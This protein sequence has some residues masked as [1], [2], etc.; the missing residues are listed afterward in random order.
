MSGENKELMGRT[1]QP[2]EGQMSRQHV[3]VQALQY[4]RIRFLTDNFPSVSLFH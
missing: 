3:E 1:L 4:N 2:C